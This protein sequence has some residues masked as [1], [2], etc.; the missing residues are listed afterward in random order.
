[1]QVYGSNSCFEKRGCIFITTNAKPLV[2]HCWTLWISLLLLLLLLLLLFYN[3]NLT[4]TFYKCIST[5]STLSKNFLQWTNKSNTT[6]EPLLLQTH[7]Q[8]SNCKN[9]S[10]LLHLPAAYRTSTRLFCNP[11]ELTDLN[12]FLSNFNEL[13][14]VGNKI[15]SDNEHRTHIKLTLI[16]FC[17]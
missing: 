1:M 16:K 8:S 7:L 14:M 11:V 3:P 4:V 17:I 6:R 15:T 9:L 2:K 12:I 5:E 10:H 13:Q